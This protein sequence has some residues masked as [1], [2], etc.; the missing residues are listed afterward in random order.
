M[1]ILRRRPHATAQMSRSKDN[2]QEVLLVFTMWAAGIEL[3]SLAT[4]PARTFLLYG[5]E[6]ECEPSVQCWQLWRSQERPSQALRWNRLVVILSQGPHPT[7]LCA[8]ASQPRT[9]GLT[10]AA[11]YASGCGHWSRPAGVGVPWSGPIVGRLVGADTG[12]G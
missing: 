12:Q 8:G 7:H 9:S 3:R 5:H 2:F 1:S 11:P 6:P 4:L 10:P